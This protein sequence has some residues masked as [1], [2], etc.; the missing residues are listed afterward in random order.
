M[1]QVL[2]SDDLDGSDA[3]ETVKF[4][5]LG[6]EYEIDLNDKNYASFEKADRQVPRRCPQDRWPG[7]WRQTV[8]CDG[9]PGSGA[10]LGARAGV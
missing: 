6:A 2:L 8:R 3:T 7:P 1:V 10:G 4:G 9:R 5:W